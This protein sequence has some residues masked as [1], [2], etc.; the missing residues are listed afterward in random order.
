ML[1]IF[2]SWKQVKKCKSSFGF[3]FSEKLFVWSKTFC[4]CWLIVGV[5]NFN[6]KWKILSSILSNLSSKNASCKLERVVDAETIISLRYLQA[7]M[8][9]KNF[10]S[11]SFFLVILKLSSR[12]LR[13][14]DLFLIWLS[15]FHTGSWARFTKEVDSYYGD[16]VQGSCILGLVPRRSSRREGTDS[17]E[18][19]RE[20]V[21]FV[22]S[23]VEEIRAHLLKLNLHRVIW[24]SRMEECNMVCGAMVRDQVQV[25]STS[26]MGVYSRD[27]GGMM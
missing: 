11:S 17:P 18:L 8:N 4:L 10:S 14:F 25:D 3:L 16:A 12:S 23:V 26:T 21:I 27:R 6:F 1:V 7:T 2:I 5:V 9:L 22:S 13:L 19:F 15:D 20:W 24:S